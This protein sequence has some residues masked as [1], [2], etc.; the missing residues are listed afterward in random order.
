MKFVAPNLHRGN[1]TTVRRGKWLAVAQVGDPLCLCDM[2]DNVLG[3]GTIKKIRRTSLECITQ[4]EIDELACFLDTKTM[5]CL[6]ETLNRIYHNFNPDEVAVVHFARLPYPDEYE[7]VDYGRL[8][9]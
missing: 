5:E 2:D 1:N 6:G 8:D 7:I 4:V 3:F 9:K